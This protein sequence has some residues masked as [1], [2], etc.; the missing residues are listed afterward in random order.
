MEFLSEA[1]TSE[2]DREYRRRFALLEL[3]RMDLEVVC[4]VKI[5]TSGNRRAFPDQS[6]IV[7]GPKLVGTMDRKC[8][9]C[10]G[11]FSWVSGGRGRPP[12]MCSPVCRSNAKHR[13]DG[14][15]NALRRRVR[16]PAQKSREL[17]AAPRNGANV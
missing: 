17:L 3:A 6:R 4:G 10:G 8:E 11:P 7:R 5:D 12:R 15:W 2:N 1:A 13:N 16:T 14:N 9:L